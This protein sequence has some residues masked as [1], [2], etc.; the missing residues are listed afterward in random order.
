MSTEIDWQ[1]ELDGSFGDGRDVPAG[2]YVAAGRRAVRRRRQL[3]AALT[4]AA[5]VLVGGV[6]WST[7]PGSAPRSEAPV[8]SQGADPD[9]GNDKGDE[10]QREKSRERRREE[11]E[12]L[13]SAVDEA[14]ALDG[15]F[16]GNP[17]TL[18]DGELV[19]APG[20]GPVLER[21]PNPMGYAPGSTRTSIGI[22]VMFRGEERYSLIAAEDD[23]R[24]GGTSLHTN[25]ATGDFAGW[26]DYRVGLQRTLDTTGDTTASATETSDAWLTLDSDGA[27]ASASPFVAVVETRQ[28]DLG[29]GFALESDRT[30]VA[31]LQVAGLPEF[32][33]WRVV[34]DELEVVYGGGRFESLDAFTDWAR[35]QY[36]SGEG[37][38]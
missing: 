24:S 35:Q 11:L 31:R 2:H 37:L 23:E 13:Q 22:R 27:V 28:V 1:R 26:L 4:T 6:V 32:V 30:G 33:A 38:R 3:A 21:V 15:E 25:T 14:V 19:L 7:S 8:A 10:A 18:V 17:A 16:V 20:A 5:V 9:Q 36:A 29:D 12:G 34:D